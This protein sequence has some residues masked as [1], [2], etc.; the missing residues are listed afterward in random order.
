[1]TSKTKTKPNMILTLNTAGIKTLQKRNNLIAYMVLTFFIVFV[2]C[3]K[4]WKGFTRPDEVDLG[5]MRVPS[6]VC[7]R[8]HTHAHRH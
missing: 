2:I 4:D 3:T 6:Y 7:R 8:K 1:M 5:T